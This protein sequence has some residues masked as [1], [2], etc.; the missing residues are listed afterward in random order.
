MTTMKYPEIPLLEKFKKDSSA[1]LGIRSI[2]SILRQIDA[3]LAEYHKV[4][5]SLT[6]QEA[7]I[8]KTLV[9]GRLYSSIDAWLKEFAKGQGKSGRKDA[10]QALFECTCFTLA[11]LTEKTINLLPRWIEETYGRGINEHAVDLD[12]TR[13]V[14]KYLTQS[15]A[16]SHRVQFRG[17]IAKQLNVKAGSTSL[18]PLDTATVGKAKEE[19]GQDTPEE[20]GWLPGHSGYVLSMGGDFFSAKHE[21]NTKGENFY[22]SS[23]MAGSA[24]KCAGTW[25]VKLGRVVEITDASGHYKPTQDHLIRAVETLKANGVNMD[26]LRV[27]AF[28]QRE[29]T[30]T[31]FLKEAPQ[32]SL[33]EQKLEFIKNE[34]ERFQAKKEGLE[35][36]AAGEK[37]EYETFAK[38]VEHFR[39]KSHVDKAG[40]PTRLPALCSLCGEQTDAL[41]KKAQ[42]EA[43]KPGSVKR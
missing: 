5:A 2:D 25:L 3:Q 36:K 38:M 6:A 41:K 43:A 31:E 26:A 15:E 22:H 12:Y 7:R 19:G 28:G 9:L 14:A 35:S 20:Q 10:I 34:T 8:Q 23:Y 32:K 21:L 37:Q 11:A 30:G 39:K 27:F 18:V 1:A 4:G 33:E 13:R 42:E 24:V 16:D 29:R 17:G 40:K